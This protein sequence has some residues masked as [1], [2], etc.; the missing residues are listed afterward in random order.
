[1]GVLYARFY[2]KINVT[3]TNFYKAICGT[4][5]PVQDYYL[6]S[7]ADIPYGLRKFSIQSTSRAAIVDIAYQV[8]SK[9]SPVVVRWNLKSNNKGHFVL[10]YGFSD[11]G[12]TILYAEPSNGQRKS[13]SLSEM[14]ENSHHKWTHSV[15]DCRK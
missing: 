9:R 2:G 15:Y 13:L 12:N 7:V 5:A 3:Q 14:T 4:N 11:Y 10:A 6:P 1:M 8:E